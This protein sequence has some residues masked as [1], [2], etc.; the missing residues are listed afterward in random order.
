MEQLNPTIFVV[1]N[2][3]HAQPILS[4]YPPTCNLIH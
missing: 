4:L 3:I 1:A 2:S